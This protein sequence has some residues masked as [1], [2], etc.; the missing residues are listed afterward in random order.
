MYRLIFAFLMLPLFAEAKVVT[1]GADEVSLSVRYA[2]VDGAKDSIP[3]YLRLPR[4][5][6]RVDNA[7]MFAV[8]AASSTGMQPDYRE[9]EIR[10]RVSE[11][12]QRIEVLLN[13]GTVVKLRL[14][15][16]NSMDAPAS[17]DLEARRVHQES[18]AAS[19]S[20]AQGQI[21]DLSVLRAILQGE[22]PQGFAKRNYGIPVSCSGSGPRARLLRVY[23]NEQFKVF[24]IEIWND[25][26]K[27]SFG[28]KE[29][30]IVF[31]TRDLSRSPLI[32]LTSSTLN[33]SGKGQSKSVM[34]ILT[35]PSANINKMRICD[36]GEQVEVIDNK[37]KF[38]R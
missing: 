24:Q 13:D 29:E 5:I 38:Q 8:K 4:A 19:S 3:T 17:Y 23:E 6:A 2:L 18:K 30:N 15:I 34:T 32:H 21:A 16:T 36:L 28:L 9:L 12:S 14:K 26:Y 11:G 33:P 35:D 10:P 31:K 7:T 27:K 1:F 20:Q 22:P 37:T 25:N